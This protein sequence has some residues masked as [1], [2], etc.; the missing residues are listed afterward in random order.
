VVKANL[1]LASSS[2]K[3]GQ[4]VL[5]LSLSSAQRGTLSLYNTTATRALVLEGVDA[6]LH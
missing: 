4:L 5:A 6:Y 3:H 2:S 1:N